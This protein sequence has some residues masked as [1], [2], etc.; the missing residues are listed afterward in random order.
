MEYAL[1]VT[2]GYYQEYFPPVE[3]LKM[4]TVNAGFGLNLNTGCIEEGMLAD[5]M[6]VEQLSD[7]PILS[8]INRT[9]SKNIIGLM[10]DGKLVYLR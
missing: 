10:T 1:K 4:A 3:I 5:I 8:L 7:N 6:M 2:R 9:E